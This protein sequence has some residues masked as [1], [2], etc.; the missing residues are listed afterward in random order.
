MLDFEKKKIEKDINILKL[1]E[2]LEYGSR[3]L[4]I[5]YTLI[6]VGIIFLIGVVLKEWGLI[7]VIGD[8][9]RLISPFFMGLVIAW[10]LSPLVSFFEEKGLK[11]GFASFISFLLLLLFI[12]ILFSLIIPFTYDQ[13]SDFAKS[14]PSI[15]SE[16]SSFINKTVTN[17][18]E[19]FNANP[20][21]ISK[22]I[23]NGISSFAINFTTSLPNKITK[24]IIPFLTG[25]IKLLFAF[26]IGFYLLL[27]FSKIREK[28]RDMIPRKNKKMVVSMI[29]RIEKTLRVYLKNLFFVMI[30]L[31]TVQTFSFYL[32]G[33]EAPLVFGIFC[34]FTNII[35]YIGPYIGGIPAVLVG[36]S[37]DPKVGIFTMIAVVL[38][39]LIESNFLTPVIM[40]KKMELHPV[41]IMLNLALFGYL[42]GFI[43]MLIATPVLSCL[44]IVFEEIN[45]N[46]EL[47]KLGDN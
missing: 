11:R 6:L 5:I 36:F 45:N 22:E 37:I 47:I 42:F 29:G 33:L 38:C 12:G 30:L 31:G 8:I 28:V 20:N 34:A 13:L 2:V 23:Y 19:R 1:N 9:L 21:V 3:T 17:I 18:A 35:P 44:K 26:M 46:Y 16:I 25:G 14:V 4:K 10:V 41:A 7:K 43:G 27:D 24:F 32:A 15:A 40:S 39:Q